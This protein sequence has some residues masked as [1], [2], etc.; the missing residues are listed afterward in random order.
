MYLS[1]VNCSE[2]TEAWIINR[3]SY[4][5]TNMKKKPSRRANRQCFFVYR[6]YNKR[7]L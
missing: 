7:R 5:K 2:I 1:F 6:T 4:L 3:I